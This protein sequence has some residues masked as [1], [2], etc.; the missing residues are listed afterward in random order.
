MLWSDMVDRA[1]IPFEPSDETKQKAK[2][3][4]EEAQQDFA[5]HSR[6][7]QR[8]LSIFIDAGD[9]T[10]ALP[11]DFIE[12]SG[13]IEFRNRVLKAYRDKEKM[14]RRNANDVYYTGIPTNYDIQGN[15]I[16]LYPS[17]SQ[18]GILQFK[19]N[20]T[21]N[22]AVDSATA[23]K[24]LNYKDLASN[25]FTVGES[26][27]GLTS[28]ATGIIFEDISDNKTGTLVLTDIS[29]T[30]VNTEQIV[31]IDEE[32]TME[33]SLYNTMTELLVQWDK[34]GLGG[35]ATV[36]G[37]PYPH[38]TAGDKPAVQQ[39]YHPFLIDYSKAMLFEDLGDYSKSDKHMQRYM[40]NRDTVKAQHPHRH[41]YG[42]EQVIDVL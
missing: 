40:F 12:I 2:R 20:A 23:Y 9:H 6:C 16:V 8:N 41:L 17:P 36:N 26:V 38:A 4:L 31:Q 1:S 5:F 37:S 15:N 25:Y 39:A 42:S 35:R 32:Q 27:Q 21:V 10:I 13:Y 7:Y 14:P 29:G 28:N 19:Y 33:R 34:L 24:K 11:D 18:T 3:Y 22:N 30:F